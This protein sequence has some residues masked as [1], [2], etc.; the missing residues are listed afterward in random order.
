MDKL[1]RALHPHNKLQTQCRPKIRVDLLR[2]C[3]VNNGKR[4]DLGTVSK[5]SQLLQCLLR[6]GGQAVQLPNHEVHHI[7]GVTLALNA[8]QFPRPSPIAESTRT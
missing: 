1:I 5:A 6:F 7:I 2:G 3:S 4:G 8:T